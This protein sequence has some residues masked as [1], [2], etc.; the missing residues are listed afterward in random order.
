MNNF[1]IS[2]G[3]NSNNQLL[4]PFPSG[5]LTGINYN[6][7][8]GGQNV[9]KI[10]VGVNHGVA[11]FFDTQFGSYI[12]GWGNN[13]YNQYSINNNFIYKNFEAGDDSTY[14]VDT[15][16]R[17]HAYGKPF[18]TNIDSFTGSIISWFINFQWPATPA[19]PL[20][21]YPRNFE[22]ISAGSG[23]LLALNISGKITG[24]GN[25]GHPVINNSKF[26]EINS[27]G[28][29]TGIS[30]G[31]GHALALFKDGSITG[32]GSGLATFD[33]KVIFSGAKVSAKGN[34][35]V[36]IGVVPP[37]VT[38]INTGTGLSNW[39]IR[40]TQTGKNIT[41]VNIQYST[42]QSEWFNNIYSGNLIQNNQNIISGNSYP[43]SNANYF[44]RVIETE[45]S[46]CQNRGWSN[47]PGPSLSWAK[48]AMS[49]DGKYQS[50]IYT[51][52]ANNYITSSSDYGLTWSGN[53]SYPKNWQ[54][55][56]ISANGALRSAVAFND[57]IY[58]STDFG[59]TWSGVT[60]VPNRSW[61]D[62]AISDDGRT[63]AAA[64]INSYIHI[65]HNS[66]NTW[67]EITGAGLRNWF[68]IGVSSGGRYQSAVT[69]FSS[70]PVFYSENSGLSWASGSGT[71]ATNW[72]DVEVSKNGRVQIA[73]PATNGLSG[74]ISY[75]YGKTWSP[76]VWFG[77]I[78]N[79]VATSFDGQYQLIAGTT[80]NKMLKSSDYGFTWERVGSNTPYAHCAMSSDGK[81]QS[82][83]TPSTFLQTNCNYGFDAI[84]GSNQKTGSTVI[85]NP[86]TQRFN[87]N[88]DY[89]LYSW[90]DFNF[91][92][93]WNVNESWKLKSFPNLTGSILTNILFDRNG[94]NQILNYGSQILQ[95][96]DYG[97]SW[98][99]QSS[100]RIG[101]IFFSGSLMSWSP[102]GNNLSFTFSSNI[103]GITTG[104]L[105]TSTGL[106]FQVYNTNNFYY[107]SNLL[108]GN[109]RVFDEN[110]GSITNFT[111]I[112][113]IRNLS[114][115]SSNLFT[116][117]V[118][119]TGNFGSRTLGPGNLFLLRN[120]LNSSINFTGFFK[121][122]FYTTGD[123]QIVNS[124]IL[125]ENAR[126]TDDKI[127]YGIVK[128]NTNQKFLA[129]LFLA[130]NSSNLFSGDILNINST[131]KNWF[132]L[133]I[134]ENGQY[135][136]A[137]EQSGY[138]YTSKDYGNTWSQSN[139]TSGVWSKVVL[140]KNGKFQGI[141]ENLNNNY[142][143]LL[144]KDYGTTWSKN[145]F[146]GN[147][148]NLAIS[149]SGLIA[150]INDLDI[151]Y[152]QINDNDSLNKILSGEKINDISAGYNYNL[153]LT[154]K[155]LSSGAP[156]LQ[157]Q[158]QLSVND[159]LLS[160]VLGSNFDYTTFNEIYYFDQIY[161]NKPSYLSDSL[162]LI[163][164]SENRWN[165]YYRYKN[166]AYISYKNTLY[167]WQVP[168][169]EWSGF[170]TYQDFGNLSQ[171][172][173]GVAI[174]CSGFIFDS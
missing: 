51:S 82:A 36:I 154:D 62:I 34:N 124:Q 77:N 87:I 54:S 19:P 57:R 163:R 45:D 149:N 104:G 123:V 157:I 48:V 160:D 117:M 35:N 111:G 49:S 10:S 28:F 113:L 150:V 98:F 112:N 31:Y 125:W 13:D 165:I 156:L 12:T 91:D 92:S 106:A 79:S 135:Q 108:T 103:S 5:L 14:L 88:N 130:T 81:Y 164:W 105:S 119:E 74:Y 40:Y 102:T 122:S 136:T 146:F 68:R 75:N 159:V 83:A 33:N 96:F 116:A 6:L 143:I 86:Q 73:L 18:S 38:G 16:G 139:A 15:V 169:N 170:A 128:N 100:A 94:N 152:K 126:I 1:L 129:S 4:V 67:S 32:W 89:R 60:S 20:L 70:F 171:F 17:I 168:R 78:A 172:Q 47:I 11:Q 29:V 148:R 132:D 30:A 142:D 9:Q 151:Y 97:Q 58:I 66:G 131:N 145:N 63:Q 56:A 153:V 109:F 155:P 3:S 93:P 26:A 21:L 27:K 23:Y 39:V 107:G 8:S 24:W 52:G 138:I 162:N 121:K 90:P 144:S 61:R 2:W 85:F 137:L 174:T 118:S 72:S 43:T 55:V 120:N 166:L 161:N 141:I 44:V 84:T 173:S 133:D 65:S 99:P 167:P 46:F 114:I 41:G 37:I 101:N 69:T 42:N 127:V 147:W 71:P 140:S 53:L 59:N 115:H 110:D 80:V 64:A 7:S 25:S 50:A 95:S 22:S 158:P 134:S 76:R